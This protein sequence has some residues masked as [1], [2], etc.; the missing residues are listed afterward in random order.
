MHDTSDR[1]IDKLEMAQHFFGFGRW[2]APFWFIGPEQGKG[3]TE[4]AD[5]DLRV[6]AWLA[7]GRPDICDCRSF[8]DAI[9]ENHWHRDKPRLQRT[10]RSLMLL[11]M[12]ASGRPYDN[13]SLRSYQRTLWGEGESGETCVIELS[14]VA[15]RSLTTPAERQCFLDQRIEMIRERVR[16]HLPAV[17]VLYAVSHREHSE[18]IAGFPL[19][20]DRIHRRDQTLF[21]LTPH[22]VAHG[23]RDADW[24]RVGEEIRVE[25]AV[26]RATKHPSSKE[27]E[28]G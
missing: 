24:I 15:A 6:R 27:Q 10:W 19:T 8:H 4:A 28:T 25:L 16:K 2:D 9:G 17:V 1:S 14:A 3:P 5:N 22:P 20:P 26:N 18:R 11:L 23:R 7:L 12:T 13:S 21:I